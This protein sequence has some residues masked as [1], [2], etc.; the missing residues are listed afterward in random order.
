MADREGEAATAGGNEPIRALFTRLT[1]DIRTMIDAEIALVRIDFYRRVARAKLAIV[2]IVGALLLGQ[3]AA[4]VLLMSLAFALSPYLTPFGG[5]MVAALV[6]AGAA[7]LCAKMGMKRLVSMI[8]D[9][10]DE[11]PQGAIEPLIERA[12]ARSRT[13]RAAV[14]DAIGD[15]QAR[16]HPRTLLEDVT[17]E[18]LDHAQTMAHRA[19]DKVRQQPFRTILWVAGGVLLVVRPRLG[20]FAFKVAQRLG[21]TRTGAVGYRGEGAVT[22]AQPPASEETGR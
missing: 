13:A 4:V 8:E 3:A 5:A 21:A 7:A 12:R 10:S 11:R 1:A 14:L 9:D 19:V 15:A 16:L 20:S 22:P 2:L 18:V 17:E 6:G